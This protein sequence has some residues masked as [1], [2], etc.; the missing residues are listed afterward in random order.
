MRLQ[1]GLGRLEADPDPVVEPTRV[2]ATTPDDFTDLRDP[3]QP[4]ITVFLYRITLH[5]ETRNSLRRTLPDGRTTRPLRA[6]S[7]RPASLA[8]P[9][10]SRCGPGG[11]PRADS[12]RP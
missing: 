6:G 7:R 8:R 3:S 5:A 10:R 11:R 12:G 4:T 2:L 9:A 1:P